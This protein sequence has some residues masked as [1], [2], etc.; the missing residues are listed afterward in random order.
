MKLVYDFRFN[1][2]TAASHVCRHQEFHISDQL[3]CCNIF[4]LLYLEIVF[5]CY[6]TFFKFPVVIDRIVLKKKKT[7]EN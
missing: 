6:I 3:I 5:L 7:R 1:R 4:S 2:L